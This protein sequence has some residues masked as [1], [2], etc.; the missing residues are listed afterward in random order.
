MEVDLR[1]IQD[2]QAADKMKQSLKRLFKQ[3]DADGKGAISSDVFFR[4]VASEGIR[5]PHNASAKL[6]K[7]CRAKGNGDNIQFRE[8]L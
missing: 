1:K 7:E 5:L 6:Q 2:K 3:I 8:A 4:L